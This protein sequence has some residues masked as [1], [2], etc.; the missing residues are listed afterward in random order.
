M[1]S[2]KQLETVAD[3]KARLRAMCFPTFLSPSC[4]SGPFSLFKQS[5]HS[6]TSTCL[7]TITRAEL[8]IILKRQ[9]PLLFPPSA[10]AGLA[11]L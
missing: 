4:A 2:G 3:Y 5:I 1:A 9:R 7:Q 6:S 8:V 10:A 11:N